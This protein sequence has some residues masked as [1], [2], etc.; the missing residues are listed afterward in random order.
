NDI[1]ADSL[2]GLL[3]RFAQRG[4]RFVKL[5][6]AMQHPAY[7]TVDDLVTSFGPSWLWRWTRSMNLNV[8]FR[9]DPEPP[10][11]ILELFEESYSSERQ[12]PIADSCPSTPE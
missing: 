11:W 12:C 2:D 8:S 4:Y 5:T 7:N 1:N 10:E 3:D 6:D 9:G